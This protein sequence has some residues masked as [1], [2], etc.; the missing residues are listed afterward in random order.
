MPPESGGG[1]RDTANATESSDA[2]A[3]E[4]AAT[5]TASAMAPTMVALHGEHRS[6]R[7]LA[8]NYLAVGQFEL[9]R[10]ALRDLAALAGTLTRMQFP[11]RRRHAC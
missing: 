8:S 9:A 4:L 7:Q 10:A 1:A 5:A 11:P 3:P 6:L 2:P